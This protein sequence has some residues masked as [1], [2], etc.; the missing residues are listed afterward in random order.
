MAEQKGM[1]AGGV[2]RALNV[3]SQRP[4]GSRVEGE[5]AVPG[6]KQDT[7]LGGRWGQEP[8]CESRWPSLDTGWQ[9]VTTETL[10]TAP[11][12]IP[13]RQGPRVFEA[14]VPECPSQPDNEQVFGEDLLD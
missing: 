14:L 4:W 10:R 12:Q 8:S 3:V 2:L 6:G 9:S 5:A 1:G 11:Q 7:D 13:Q